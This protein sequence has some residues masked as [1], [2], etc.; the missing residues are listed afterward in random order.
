MIRQATDDYKIARLTAIA[1]ILH[2]AEFFVPSP[3][4]GIKPGIANIIIL[5][6]FVTLNFKSAV[7]VSLIRVFISS[8]ILG[9]FLTPTFFISL[10]GAIFSLLFLYISS[11]LNKNYF[12]IISISLLS[13]LGHI[14][15]QFIIVRIFVIPD[16]GIFFL[17]PIFLGSAIIFSLINAFILSSLIDESK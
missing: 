4:Y 8:L 10:F 13:G 2:A 17:L 11:F 6:A 5:F 15:G 9:M 16:D 12:S 14:L 3:V 7:L 1:I